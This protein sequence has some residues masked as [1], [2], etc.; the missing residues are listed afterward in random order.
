MVRL[1]DTPARQSLCPPSPLLVLLVL[2][3]FIVYVDVD[4]A[5]DPAAAVIMATTFS[6]GPSRRGQR[7]MATAAAKV[8]VEV[9][10]V[11]AAQLRLPR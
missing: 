3:L 9:E 5:V 2:L 1:P 8:E 6:V 10:V 11:A 7:E 4:A